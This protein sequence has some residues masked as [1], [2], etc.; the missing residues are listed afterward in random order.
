VTPGGRLAAAMEILDEVVAGAPAERCLTRWARG[1]RF[2]G[3]KDR[4]AIRDTVFDVLRTRSS[5]LWCAG[6]LPES[7]RALITGHLAMTAPE[8][9]DHINGQGFAPAALSQAEQD[10]VRDLSAASAHVIEDW[11]EFLMPEVT[12]SLG[13]NRADVAQTLRSRAPVDLR[14][15]VHKAD[16]AKAQRALEQAGVLTDEILDV[17]TG[18][19]VTAGARS[20][21]GSPAY[22]NG[23]VELQDAASQCVAGMVAPEPGMT[24]LDLCAGGGGKTLAMAAAMKGQGRLLAYD[25][26]PARMRDIPQRAKRAGVRIEIANYEQVEA[27]SGQFDCVLADV[28]CSGSGAW[29]RDPDQKWRL[30]QGRLDEIIV[31]QRRILDRAARLVR[32]GGRLVFATCSILRC[33]NEDQAMA[34]LA[35]WPTLREMGQH[36]F[37]P[38]DPGDGF[39]CLVA[40]AN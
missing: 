3:S 21:A 8:M 29:R 9:L 10:A 30:S 12:R 38:G 37:W 27:L 17:P 40:A 7:G 33:E 36:R 18:L 22:K 19:R 34:L 23:L 1:H 24:V 11:P 28:P 20:V 39:F 16:R 14:V 5:S 25:V 32:P 15:N 35:R 2:A 31:L 13:P 4:A 6:G 26:N